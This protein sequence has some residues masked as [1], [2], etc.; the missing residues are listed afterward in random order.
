MEGPHSVE[1]QVINVSDQKNQNSCTKKCRS[2]PEKPVQRLFSCSCF[3]EALLHALI[4]SLI[5]G[6][7][8][9][10]VP[11]QELQICRNCGS[12]KDDQG[13]GQLLVL[14]CT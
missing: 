14:G 5:S 6:F 8:E 13:N 3:T 2:I 1:R 7:H 12:C 9:A 4:C 11:D 10:A